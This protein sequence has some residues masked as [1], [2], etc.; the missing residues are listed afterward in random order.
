MEF[1]QE[2]ACGAFVHRQ[3]TFQQKR[4]RNG[5]A[6]YHSVGAGR[7]SAGVTR[8]SIVLELPEHCA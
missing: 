4:S 2:S 8:N 5:L 3:N 1:D 6:F 7:D